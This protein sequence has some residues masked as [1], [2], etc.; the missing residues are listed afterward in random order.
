MEKIR[1]VLS[2]LRHFI[3]ETI[4]TWNQEN[5][6]PLTF[7]EFINSTGLSPI[8]VLRYRTWSEWKAIAKGEQGPSDPDIHLLRKALSRIALRSDPDLL[9]Q[10]SSNLPDQRSLGT[11][12]ST[13]L[14]YLRWGKTGC[15]LGMANIEDSIGRW[16]MNP[17]VLA[18][19]A[20]VAA[21]RLHRFETTIRD[22]ELPFPCIL[23]LHA[24]YGSAE[25][26][27]ALGLATLDRSGP[28]GQGVLHASDH[29]CYVHLVTFRKDERVFSPTTRYRDYPISAHRLHWESQSTISQASRT[30]Q[31]Y[32]SYRD[33]GYTVLF[34]ARL[35]RQKDGETAPFIYLGPAK[36]LL[37]AEGDRPI[38]MV[39]ELEYPM[40]AYLLQEAMPVSSISWQT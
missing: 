33:L 2:D 36:K 13:A 30:G 4:K 5:D 11:E 17:T 37:S 1:A 16:N 38:R 21:W 25:I 18:D 19:A 40:P 23:K 27:A 20:E 35:E 29:K 26:K 3:P 7:G 12:T 31:N 8:D 24:E 28:T 22:I 15:S 39:W 32:L 10:F 34:F 9:R 14:H 6:C